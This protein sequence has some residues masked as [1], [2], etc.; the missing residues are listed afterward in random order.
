LFEECWSVI[1][2]FDMAD[3]NQKILKH[4]RGHLLGGRSVLEEL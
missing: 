4:E 3:R 1:G 2:R